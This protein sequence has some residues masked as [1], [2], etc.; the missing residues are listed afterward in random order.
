MRYLDGRQFGDL[1]ASKNA[2][3]GSTDKHHGHQPESKSGKVPASTAE[4]DVDSHPAHEQSLANRAFMQG[5][6]V[7]IADQAKCSALLEQQ[8]TNGE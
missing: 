8:S 6:S 3:A 2:T 1:A 7:D 4:L 5:C